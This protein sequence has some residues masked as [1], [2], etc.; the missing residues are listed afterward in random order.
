VND[1]FF[2][3]NR[4]TYIP[5]FTLEILKYNQRGPSSPIP[6]T[7]LMIGNPCTSELIDHN[8]FFPLAHS[9]DL[10]PAT[11]KAAIESTCP[12]TCRYIVDN[13]CCQFNYSA[14][15]PQSPACVANL[16]EMYTLFAN[17]N[18]YDIYSDCAS[19]PSGNAPC[20]GEGGM[21]T[22]LDTPAIRNAIHAAP[23]SATGPWTDCTSSKRRQFFF[24]FSFFPL[25]SFQDLN[26][27]SNYASIADSVYPLIFQMAPTLDVMI[28]SGDADACVPFFGTAQWTA[29]IG[30]AVED[31]WRPWQVNGQLAGYTIGYQ[32]LRFTTIKGC[33]HMAPVRCACF[34]SCFSHLR[35]FAAIQAARVVCD[36]A[37]LLERPI[38][39]GSP[40]QAL[41]ASPPS[42]CRMKNFLSVEVRR[43]R[44]PTI[45]AA[46]NPG[47]WAQYVAEAAKSKLQQAR[48]LRAEGWHSGCFGSPCG[49]ATAT[50]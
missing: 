50:L 41:V 28:Y 11:L 26:Y 35:P 21:P 14:Y 9:H 2:H 47:L 33:G 19:S 46:P 12:P 40:R 27:T 36:A 8:A 20:I 44:G 17:N 3:G 24:F 49:A 29:A 31:A 1:T 34:P 13:S 10:I 16:N 22:F 5:T 18:L 7:G 6:L 42:R 4:R 45:A 23:L 39:R 25:I 32:R 30:G 43:M 48:E 15:P 38:P 37:K